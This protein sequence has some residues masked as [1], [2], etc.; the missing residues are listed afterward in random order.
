MLRSLRHRARIGALLS[1]VAVPCALAAQR[2]APGPDLALT[3]VVGLV[4]ARH[5][6]LAAASARRQGIVA[7]ALQ[8]AAF[9]NPTLG[10]RR[11]NLGSPLAR[12]AFYTVAQ[13][14]DL[15]GRRFAL[16]AGA[17]DLDRRGLLDSTTL[18]RDLEAEAARA[19]WRASLARAVLAVSEEHRLD[20]ERL[21]RMEAERAREGAVAEVAAMRT[22][23]AY[24]HA[25]VAEATAH[26]EWTRAIA[27]LA[28]AVR[29]RAESLP[30]VAGLTAT[31]AHESSVVHLE[32]A[33]SFATALA[34][35]LDRRTE[36]AAFRAAGDAARHRVS[37]ARLGV[38]SDV[39]VEAGTKQTAGLTTR[40]VGVAVPLPL[41]D[42]NSAARDR[43]TAD[44]QLVQA[45]L[46]ATEHVVRTEVAGALD[47]YR[48]LLAARP[49][50]IDSL[51]TRANEV[52][53]I[54]AGAYAAGG[55]SL[56]ELLDARRARNEA[57][58]A[59]LRW[60]ADVQLARLD[61]LRALGASPLDTL[62]LP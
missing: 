4:R 44:F 12:D 17:R 58:T 35:A 9:P 27:E 21:A 6:S 60:V 20:A 10:W 57:L 22:S 42:R 56:L 8:E 53:T 39:V 55:G 29:V 61:L 26:A 24:D 3:D 52:A 37:A 1:L 7:G 45:E 31:M 16:R 14:L 51:V 33:P 23:V 43:A 49:D 62:E 15:T 46:R 32:P 36:L 19:F 11:E 5:P 25:R 48:A 18:A 40:V 13:P 30:P 28:R 38:L 2:T 50:G 54:A 34:Y 41:F 47:A 59:A